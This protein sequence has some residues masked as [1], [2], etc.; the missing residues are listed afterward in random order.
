MRC[1]EDN[2]I[3]KKKIR[4]KMRR[5]NGCR[6]IICYRFPICNFTKRGFDNIQNF[7]NRVKLFSHSRMAYNLARVYVNISNWKL[8]QRMLFY[9]I[10]EIPHR[11]T[12]PEVLFIV[13]A[14][15]IFIKTPVATPFW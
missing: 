4:R 12:R 7:R 2:I 9:G 10:N 15:K 8:L 11:N 13:A 1:R 6:K 3:R 5:K 14:R